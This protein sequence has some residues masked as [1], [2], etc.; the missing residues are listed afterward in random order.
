MS[1]VQDKSGATG[2]L[3]AVAFTHPVGPWYHVAIVVDGTTM[4][5]Y[6]NGVYEN[7][8]PCP[9]AEGCTPATAPNLKAPWPLAYKGIG[10]GGT[11]LGCRYTKAAFLKGAIRLARFTPRALTPAEFIP[12][13]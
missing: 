2:R 12:P 11:S 6:V 10:A 3:Y 4:K 5:H 7:A 1:F 9:G 8:G 13:P